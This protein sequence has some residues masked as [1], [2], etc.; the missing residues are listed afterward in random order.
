ML[1]LALSRDS[2]IFLF[3]LQTA[4]ALLNPA[5]LDKIRR[6]Q[7]DSTLFQEEHMTEIEK[8]CEMCGILIKKAKKKQRF[9]S[10]D[11]QSAYVKKNR[12]LVYDESVPLKLRGS[13][14]E[15]QVC[16]DLLLM[17]FEVYS[18]VSLNA[19]CDLVAIKGDVV[20]RVEVKTAMYI[21]GVPKARGSATNRFDVLAMVVRGGTVTYSPAIE[22]IMTK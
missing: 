4:V 21:S 3:R 17:G 13:I 18:S 8:S 22:T 6:A 9:C 16:I 1:F 15:L 5:S 20:L 19:R 12:V 7:G 14:S 10:I 2:G 11:C